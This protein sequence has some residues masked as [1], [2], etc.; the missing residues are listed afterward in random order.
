MRRSR[1]TTHDQIVNAVRHSKPNP[2]KPESLLPHDIEAKFDKVH[3]DLAA[4]YASLE[5]LA[6]ETLRQAEILA[7]S[8]GKVSVVV[9]DDD[10][11]V[12]HVESART[13]IEGRKK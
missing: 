9:E 5:Y 11:L 7:D 10:S 8:D 4:Q 1:P 3:G 13:R 12:V 2:D 6:D